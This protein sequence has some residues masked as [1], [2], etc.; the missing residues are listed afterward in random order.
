MQQYGPFVEISNFSL[1]MI[2]PEILIYTTIENVIS[3]LVDPWFL[4]F[5]I[6]EK[7]TANDSGVYTLHRSTERIVNSHGLF[8]FGHFYTV[9]RIASTKPLEFVQF[10]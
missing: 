3:L 8:I 2:V 10:D 1:S 4:Y 9:L 5:I 7:M 6:N